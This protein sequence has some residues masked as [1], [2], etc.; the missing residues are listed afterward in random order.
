MPVHSGLDTNQ[1]ANRMRYN[2]KT[3]E[4]WY[5]NKMGDILM[6]VSDTA[7]RERLSA[8][9]GGG[10]GNK[11]HQWGQLGLQAAQVGLM[12]G[13]QANGGEGLGSF[14]EPGNATVHNDLD[15]GGA[16][17]SDIDVGDAGT[18]N[19]PMPTTTAPNSMGLGY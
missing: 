18:F 4:W 1:L 11:A 19:N 10:G 5:Q 14:G 6:G 8:P 9:M 16:G 13:M 17:L 12:A 7:A 2:T 15:A 3:R